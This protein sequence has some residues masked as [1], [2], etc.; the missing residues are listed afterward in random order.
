MR[1]KLIQYRYYIVF[2]NIIFSI[3]YYV[4]VFETKKT[5]EDQVIGGK[6]YT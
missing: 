1:K 3:K 2:Y 4:Y 5:R 6:F